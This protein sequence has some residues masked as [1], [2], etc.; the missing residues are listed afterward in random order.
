MVS[1]EEDAD[2]RCHTYLR[3]DHPSN[4]MDEASQDVWHYIMSPW[5][6]VSVA[7]FRE[8]LV[9]RTSCDHAAHPPSHCMPQ[10]P[11]PSLH[12][13]I[14]SI[15]SVAVT[16]GKSTNYLRCY[17]T[18]NKHSSNA[19]LSQ[20]GAS[21]CGS[22]GAQSFHLCSKRHLMWVWREWIMRCCDFNLLQPHKHRLTLISVLITL[23]AA[24]YSS[25]I[26]VLFALALSPLLLT[27]CNPLPIICLVK[28]RG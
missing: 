2:N 10:Q 1:T 21:H 27:L 12:C 22:V 8:L 20:R 24:R 23:C 28:S 16:Y 15:H 3:E 4:T 13:L 26:L 14:R 9:A 7:Q 6:P 5:Q 17:W 11:S 18:A 25:C 19:P